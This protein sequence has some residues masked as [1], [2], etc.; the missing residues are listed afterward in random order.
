MCEYF[1][2]D[3][4]R[5]EAFARS[6]YKDYIIQRINSNQV[7]DQWLSRILNTPGVPI[8]V[9]LDRDLQVQAIKGGM[10]RKE[11]TQQILQQI[12]TG[13]DYVDTA[14]QY[15]KDESVKLAAIRDYLGRQLYAQYVMDL[16]AVGGPVDAR[17]GHLEDEL[18]KNNAVYPSFYNN[19]LLSQYKLYLG[20]TIMAKQYADVALKDT[21][22]ATLYFNGSL[23]VEL[24]T[25]LNKDYSV[26]DDPYIGIDRSEIQLGNVAQGK[27]IDIPLRVKNMG[28][29]PL[30][31]GDV[32]TSCGCTVAEVPSDE[33]ASGTEADVRIKITPTGLG[34]FA[35]AVVL[36]SNAI[37]TPLQLYIK[38]T[39]ID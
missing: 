12:Q 31:I 1:E 27:T 20:D 24:K 25:L 32:F 15:G 11:Q 37:N 13:K 4:I 22:P 35:H 19:Y 3:L 38:G 17:H 33:I 5:D 26:Y 36:R 30:Q 18:L 10:L 9:F 8:Y 29:K 14:Y 21:D 39:T 23:R 28:N 6:V 34:A 16:F 7:G 2:A